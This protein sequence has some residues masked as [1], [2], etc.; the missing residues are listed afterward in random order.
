MS[1]AKGQG[2]YPAS[3][4]QKVGALWWHDRVQSE[5]AGFESRKNSDSDLVFDSSDIVNLLLLGVGFLELKVNG[6]YKVLCCLGQ[7]HV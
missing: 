6:E 2:F 3:N 4:N 7:K 1:L 5:R